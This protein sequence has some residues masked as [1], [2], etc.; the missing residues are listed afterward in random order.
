MGF[1]GNVGR[2]EW[3]FFFLRGLVEWRLERAVKAL[4]CSQHVMC[5]ISAFAHLKRNY[6][7]LMPRLEIAPT[8]K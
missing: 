7:F 5:S 8:C 4:K 1:V 6:K 2:R 3:S